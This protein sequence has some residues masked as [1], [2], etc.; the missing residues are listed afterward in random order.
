MTAYRLFDI[1]TK[2]FFVSRDVIFH[3][4]IC[5]FHTIID[6]AT[7]TDP[8]LHLVLPSPSLALSLPNIVQPLFPPFSFDQALP[9]SHSPPP[10][11]SYPMS[12]NPLLRSTR[13]S[14]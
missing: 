13:V 4:D 3:E 6:I 8:F 1:H 10:G 14:K 5:P 9:K 11:S 12:S 7:M 2:Q